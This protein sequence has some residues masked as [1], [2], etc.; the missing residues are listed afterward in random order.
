MKKAFVKVVALALALI[1]VSCM[2]IACGTKLSGTYT[3]EE[4]GMAVSF[5]FKG[6]KV[7]LE[8]DMGI[9][10]EYE[11]EGT[12]EIKDDEISF[13]FTGADEEDGFMEEVLDELTDTV[14]FEKGKDYIKIA[15]EKYEKE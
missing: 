2:F 14:K 1:T 13:D 15:G 12:Y 3:A 10:G 11:A 5:T 7:T 4:A 8:M 6:S 9:L